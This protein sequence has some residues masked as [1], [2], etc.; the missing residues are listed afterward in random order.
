ME[1]INLEGTDETPGVILDAA[2]G[3]F[4]FSGSSM[5][6]DV[7]EFYDP[8]LAWLDVYAES[9]NTQS[10]FIF[11][12]EYFNTASSKMIFDVLLKL[13]EMKE[14]GATVSVEWHYYEEDEDME[15]AGE[16]FADM[17][18]VPFTQVSYR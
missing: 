13:E 2:T 17:V 4:E 12:M 3:K 6:E 1:T 11:K 5:P 9:P 7:R 15:T 16:E 14:A 18:E 10:K 8:I